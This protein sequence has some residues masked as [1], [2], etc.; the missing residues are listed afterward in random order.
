MHGIERQKYEEFI[1]ILYDMNDQVQQVEWSMESATGSLGKY[2]QA[3]KNFKEE[4]KDVTG[5]GEKFSFE[6][7]ESKTKA[8]IKAYNEFIG[9]LL[10]K[11]GIKFDI[12]EAIDFKGL[13][14]ALGD[15]YPQLKQVVAK[16]QGEYEKLV[17]KDIDK[18]IKE[19]FVSLATNAGVSLDKLQQYFKSADQSTQ[20]WVKTLKDAK[21][22]LDNQIF[23]AKK[24][25][26]DTTALE[27]QKQVIEAMIT[28][29]DNSEKTQKAGVKSAEQALKDELSAVEK[30][31][32]RYQDL[33]KLKSETDT[34]SILA[35]EF[36]GVNLT[37]LS[38]AYSPKQMIAVYQKALA[39]A[40]RLG[41]KDLA[42]EI[43]TKLGEFNVEEQ[44]RELEQKLKDLSDK[45]SRTKTAKEFFDRMLGMTGDK[46]LSATLTM[47]VYGTTGDDLQKL[48]TKQIFD[49]F[50]GVD[51]SEAML[52]GNKWDYNVLAG[53]VEQLPEAQQKNAQS[54]VDNWRKA[55]ADILTDLQ[56]SYE[57]F[58]TYEERKTRVAEKYV[59]ERK[60]IEESQYTKDEKDKLL[61]A[62]REAEKKELGAIAIEEFKASDDWIKSFEDLE[63]LA[64]PT[65]ERLMTKLKEFITL[66]KEA[67][68]PEQLK[69]LMGEY[70]K[71]YNGL[72]T[73]N[74][75]Q[76]ITDSIKEYKSAMQGI[77]L[78][79]EALDVAKAMGDDDLIAFAERGLTDAFDDAQKATSKLQ[80]GLSGL[81][82]KFSQAQ[83]F[84]S[85]FTDTL[86]ISEDTQFGSFLNGISDALGGVSKAFAFAQLAV[87][88]FDGS[89][90]TML[91]SNPIG[92]ILLA[93]SAII[94]AVQAIANARVKR[95]DQ[96]I[97]RIEDRLDSL[98]YAY[99][100]LQKAQEKAF[101][102][103]YISNY[104][105]Q[106]ENLEA[107]QEAYLKQAE[108]ERS[109]GKKA[110]EDK[111]K[112]YEKQARDTADAIKD[113]YGS[114]SEQFLGSD[115][116]STARDFASAWIDAYKEFSNTTDAMK[117]KFQDMIQNMVVE[118]LL[119]KV[120]EK[121]LEPVFTMIDEMQEGDFYST[122]FWQRVMSTMQMATENGVV[123][124]QNVMAM[125][126]QMGINLRG[127][128]GEMTGISRDIATASEESIL[129][130]AAGINTQNFYISQVPTKLDTIIGLLRGDGAMPQG[131]TIT[132]QDVMIAQNQFLS[133]LPTIAQHTAETVAECKQIVAET[134]RTADALERVIKPDGTRTTYKMNVV[135]TYQG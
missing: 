121:A 41:K 18:L 61:R 26:K 74:P 58:M 114:L 22:E 128:G 129:G 79:Q 72:I 85:S 49:A 117:A 55:N 10:A 57:D 2:T 98:S 23:D 25:D 8:E 113:M 101:G 133:H 102:N 69:S 100:R 95:I 46:E 112:E 44:Q 66:N 34:Q 54:I 6:W 9:D 28:A 89:I 127:L 96:D 124:A 131:S 3:Y 68:T 14:E 40:Q 63:N 50:K 65:I 12:G 19:Q 11:E 60:K 76:A 70:D 51:I 90:K 120:M 62:S 16:I 119:A 108:L 110:D 43:Q 4:L 125:L 21:T 13:Y 75:I 15:N 135:T 71:L 97:E 27:A 73:R 29:W 53:F 86:G 111:I 99:D 87:Q 5:T 38:K 104:E 88:L 92:W 116:A 33:R 83:Q 48:M 91:A 31:Y 105:R 67:L 115:L 126:E 94:S 77:A 17:P 36:K 47:S 123:G 93:V 81:G 32:K 52:G 24:L 103:D 106:L 78:A 118:S 82:D 132:L 20:D 134:R 37:T 64:T 84:V 80:K 107:Q 122:S 42:L 1:D 45:I 56:K 130:L 109:K 35:N 7:N 30:I 39:E 59:A